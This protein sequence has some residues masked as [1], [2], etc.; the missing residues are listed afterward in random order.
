MKYC[1]FSVNREGVLS[2]ESIQNNIVY[3]G[4]EPLSERRSTST[5]KLAHKTT[6]KRSTH[7]FD[8]SNDVLFVRLNLA[9][10]KI[11]GLGGLQACGVDGGGH[12]GYRGICRWGTAGGKHF[13]DIVVYICGFVGLAWS[14][15][16]SLEDRIGGQRWQIICQFRRCFKAIV[17]I[18]LTPNKLSTH[19]SMSN[20][21]QLH[22]QCR[23]LENLFDA[24]LTSYSQ[25]VSTIS[26]PTDDVEAVGSSQRWKDL[27]L[28]LDDLLEKACPLTIGTYGILTSPSARGEQ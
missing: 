23:T 27:E 13:K 22:R 9:F 19:P 15:I 3:F 28:E 17:I 6:V 4:Q 24:K 7:L 8:S 26:R 18:R 12:S 20:Y 5:R 25:L 1:I 10:F 14:M 16:P 11:L 21:D 2:R